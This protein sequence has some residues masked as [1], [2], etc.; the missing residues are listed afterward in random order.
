MYL[1]EL[2]NSI[3]DIAVIFH[4]TLNP[5][6]WDDTEMNPQVRFKLLKIAQDFIK[7]IDVPN[8]NLK[9][10]TISG[11]NAAFTY[12]KNSDLDLHLVVN[13][14]D[15]DREYVIQL[16]D[17][18]KNQYNFDHNIKIKGIDVEVYIQNSAEPHYSAGIFSILDNKWISEP[19]QLKVNIDDEDVRDKYENYKSKIE[20]ALESTNINIVKIVKDRLKSLRRTGL[21]REG[22]TGI[23][24][25]TYKVLRNKGYIEKLYKHIRNIEDKQ[26]GMENINASR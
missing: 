1:R 6:L 3:V 15:K 23:E 7:F 9:D 13:I 12:T 5:T 2:H 4:D 24:N 8:I 11:S 25:I 18:K 16:F 20:M 19:K 21:E 14:P 26:L 10:I 22:E 17:A